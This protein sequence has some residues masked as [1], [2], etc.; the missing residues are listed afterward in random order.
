MVKS[1][2][3][4]RCV[5]QLGMPRSL[6]DTL[7]FLITKFCF[8]TIM[9]FQVTTTIHNLILGK[10]Y[11]SHHGTMHIKGNRQY[12]CKLKFK[13]PS[14][15]DRNPHLVSVNSNI[16]AVNRDVEPTCFPLQHFTL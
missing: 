15:L 9:P 8:H 12:S 14:L 7:Y 5:A 1:S 16:T 10:L 2:N 4:I 11:C 3:G 13:E 6:I